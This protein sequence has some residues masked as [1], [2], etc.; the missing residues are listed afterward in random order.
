MAPKIVKLLRKSKSLQNDV[1]QFTKIST[2]ILKHSR[3]LDSSMPYENSKETGLL[4]I[5]FISQESK[6]PNSEKLVEMTSFRCF[7][8]EIQISS[9]KHG[10]SRISVL[11]I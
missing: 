1:L 8:Q 2:G 4:P 6:E 11:T 3:S 7:C 9:I 10:C 5:L